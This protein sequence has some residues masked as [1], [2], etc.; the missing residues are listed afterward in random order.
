MNLHYIYNTLQNYTYKM[1]NQTACTVNI[2]LAALVLSYMFAKSEGV[3]SQFRLPV[4]KF[5]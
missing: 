1:N 2:I 5:S 3:I 4:L